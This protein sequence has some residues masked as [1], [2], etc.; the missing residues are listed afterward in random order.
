MD[1]RKIGPEQLLME[2][3]PEQRGVFYDVHCVFIYGQQCPLFDLPLYHPCSVI[4]AYIHSKK[5]DIFTTDT[6][7]KNI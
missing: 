1:P 5:S 4:A 3:D 6:H 2:S 7:L